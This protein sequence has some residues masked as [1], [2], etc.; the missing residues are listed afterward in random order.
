[1]SLTP[2]FCE[3]LERKAPCMSSPVGM[4]ANLSPPL[5]IIE[6]RYSMS[7]GIGV[8]QKNYFHLVRI[9]RLRSWQHQWRNHICCKKTERYNRDY[10]IQSDTDNR[11]KG[12]SIKYVTLRGSEKV[13]Q[14]VTG[15]LRSCDVTLSVFSQFTIFNVLFYILS[16]II[17]I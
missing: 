13:W 11:E 7:L 5:I 8:N 10:S 2:W 15:G 17:Q 3:D 1:M 16:Y 14:F 6:G 4:D 9:E 12:P